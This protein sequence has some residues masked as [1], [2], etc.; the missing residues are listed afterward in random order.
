M[1][2]TYW[3]DEKGARDSVYGETPE[4]HEPSNIDQGEDDTDEDEE[5]HPEVIEEDEGGEED[6]ADGQQEVSVEFPG[7]NLGSSML[8]LLII[9]PQKHKESPI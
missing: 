8:K 7:N 2:F 4:M 6:T 5:A 3:Y 9:E 1:T